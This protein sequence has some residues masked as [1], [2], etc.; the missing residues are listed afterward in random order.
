MTANVGGAD[1][2]VRVLAGL[3]ILS[4]FFFLDGTARWWALV[5]LGPL[6][7]GLIAWCPTYLPFGFSTCRKP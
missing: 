1:K 7:T 2:V 3:A 5:G 4:L 6:A